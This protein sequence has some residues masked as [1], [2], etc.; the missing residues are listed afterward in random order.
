MFVW[1]HASLFLLGFVPLIRAWYACRGSSL[2]HAVY[3]AV[4]AWTGWG[5]FLFAGQPE[6]VGWEPYRYVALTLT[7]C[8]I[9][10]VLGARFPYAAAWNFVV[11]GLLGVML[12]PLVEVTLL[13]TRTLDGLRLTFLGVTLGMGMLNYLP[14]RLFFFAIWTGAALG[15]EFIVLMADSLDPSFPT[16]TARHVGIW[17]SPWIGWLVV[18]RPRGGING[19]DQLWLDFRDRYGLVWGQRVREQ[20][21]AAVRNA[22]HDA[23]LTWFGLQT[24][25]T[26]LGP[27]LNLLRAVL[28][29]FMPL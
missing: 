1:L 4:A 2:E 25:E 8:P 20:F 6:S 16:S 7:A 27:L 13:G 21:N 22:G 18:L 15:F 11:L 29:R 24:K 9:V 10:A 17:L 3:W 14:T 28:K 23:T 26:D 12:L 5:L 19:V